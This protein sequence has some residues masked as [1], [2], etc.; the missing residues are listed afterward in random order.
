MVAAAGDYLTD[1]V[2]RL[3]PAC[4]PALVRA[5]LERACGGQLVAHGPKGG[6]ASGLTLSGIPFE[7]SAVGGQGRYAPVVRYL[8]EAATQATEFAARVDAQL[9]V[10]RDLVTSLP[11]GDETV[12]ELFR[13]FIATLY[14]DPAKIPARV[15]FATWIGVVHDAA[16]PHHIA[17]LKVYGSP[18]IVPGAWDRLAAGWPGFAGLTSVSEHDELFKYAVVAVEVDARGEVNHKVYLTSRDRDPAVPMKL[19]RHF[20]DPAWEALSELVRCGAD[21][22]R[23]HD[24]DYFVCRSRSS[25]GAPSFALSVA[26]RRIDD[27]TRIVDELAERHHGTTEAVDALAQAARS[28]GAQ[29]R[30][31]ALGLGVSAEHGIDKLNV[32]GTPTW[33]DRPRATAART[34]G[35]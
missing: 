21:P 3:G 12:A 16:V 22:A 19:V 10:I 33:S 18:T 15:R 20:G 4:D 13:S 14:P 28:H 31:S 17:R 24:Y 5:G 8:T 6:R 32:Y 25:D 23:L 2:E 11:N 35:R 30:W 26:T 7:V 9:A 29:W 27:V 34:S 1:V